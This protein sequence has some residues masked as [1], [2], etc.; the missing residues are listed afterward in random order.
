MEISKH[1]QVQ[2]WHQQ[3]TE[4]TLFCLPIC[5]APWLFSE[6]SSEGED[7]ACTGSLPYCWGE[8]CWSGK[9]GVRLKL[10]IHSLGPAYFS[11]LTKLW[12]DNHRAARMTFTEMPK[13]TLPTSQMTNFLLKSMYLIKR[14]KTFETDEWIGNRLPFV[15]TQRENPQIGSS[16]CL[17]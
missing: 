5:H 13:V 14:N 7:S 10:W 2:W 4:W 16:A 6:R 15:F 8:K 1:S 3:Q 9:S 17:P 12:D 11:S